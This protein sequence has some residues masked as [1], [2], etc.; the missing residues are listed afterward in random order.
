LGK[1]AKR[2]TRLLG[3][4]AGVIIA[5][6]FLAATGGAADAAS[7]DWPGAQQCSTNHCY[8]RAVDIHSNL[9]AATT[10]IQSSWFSMED[11][12]LWPYATPV[13][14]NVDC[15]GGTCPWFISRELWLGDQSHWIEIGLR[16][17]YEYPDW[18]M[19]NGAPGCG[20]QAYYEFWEDG[21]NKGATG[22]THVIANITPDNAWHTYGI[23]R[24]SGQ[25]FDVTVDGRVVGVS[26][27]SGASSFGESAI[28]SETSALT[29][30]QPLSLMNQS[31]Q[32]WSVEDSTGRWFGV[33]QP[34]D[35]LRGSSDSKT[36]SPDQTYYGTWNSTTHQ[37]CIGKGSLPAAS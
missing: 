30:V 26:T 34:S 28:G 8:S 1:S 36:S 35:G 16:N 37:L 7:P 2:L 20:C 29:T 12:T 11:Q 32:S 31:C 3:A 15:L 22:A 5:L 21:A 14:D 13:V 6:S 25:T 9:I 19:P 23:Y 4:V 24:V 17:G 18:T 27:L 33:G 10:T